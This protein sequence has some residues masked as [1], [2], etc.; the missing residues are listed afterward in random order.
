M[1]RP[2]VASINLV[3]VFLLGENR[4]LFGPHHVAIVEV[5]A[6]QAVQLRAP[7]NVFVDVEGFG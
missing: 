7:S 3:F 1:S 5:G 4:I 2:G 6:V